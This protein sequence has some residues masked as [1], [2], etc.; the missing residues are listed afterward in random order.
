MKCVCDL[1]APHLYVETPNYP[2]LW[3]HLFPSAS[4]SSTLTDG[5]SRGLGM[6]EQLVRLQDESGEEQSFFFVV[7]Y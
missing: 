6:E 7:N 1:R 2:T 5:P 3:Y 4:M